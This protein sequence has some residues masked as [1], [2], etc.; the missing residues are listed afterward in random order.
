MS[1]TRIQWDGYTALRDAGLSVRAIASALG[2]SP[3]TV[4]KYLVL[5]TTNNDGSIE[6][7]MRRGSD[8]KVRP[9]RQFNTAYRDQQIRAMR[10]DKLTTRQIASAVGC[11]PGT[12][13]RVLNGG[14]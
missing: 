6:V 14:E 4:Q 8:G 13:H 11:S 1:L 2:L 12:V 3:T 7:P 10:D 9:G 5:H